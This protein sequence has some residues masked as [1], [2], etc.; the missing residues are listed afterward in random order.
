MD[1]SSGLPDA[2]AWDAFRDSRGFYWIATL[3]GLALYD[4]YTIKT[5]THSK[6]KANSLASNWCTQI[7][8][9]KDKYIIINNYRA[10]SIYRYDYDDFVSISL[11][12]I[13]PS[14]T[15]SAISSLLISADNK[16][17]LSLNSGT[18]LV[19][20]DADMTA[21]I[22]NDKANVKPTT[23]TFDH[24]SSK[25]NSTLERVKLDQAGNMW[26]CYYSGIYLAKNFNQNPKTSVDLILPG[27]YSTVFEDAQK[28]IWLTCYSGD[29]T[30]LTPLPDGTYSTHTYTEEVRKQVSIPITGF[31]N[32]VQDND[33]LYY[34]GLNNGGLITARLIQDKLY[35]IDHIY[36]NT[37]KSNEVT[38]NNNINKISLSDNRV[39]SLSTSTGVL[40]VNLQSIQMNNYSIV[41]NNTGLEFGSSTGKII[42][43]RDKFLCATENEGVY[44]MSLNDAKH[45]ASMSRILLDN[46]LVYDVVADEST[47]TVYIA[48]EKGLLVI[49]ESQILSGHPLT[50][51]QYI[52]QANQLSLHS[53]VIISLY[54]DKN[55]VL[56]LGTGRGLHYMD[57]RSGAIYRV[58]NVRGLEKIGDN[59]IIRDLVMDS[60]HIL[61]IATNSGLIAYDPI[62]KV[63]EQVILPDTTD[64]QIINSAFVDS[65]NNLW[66]GSSAGLYIKKA[67][68]K[69][70]QKILNPYTNFDFSIRGIVEENDHTVWATSQYGLLK[71]V[72][73]NITAHYTSNDGLN[74]NIFNYNSITYTSNGKII[75]GN[76]KG[77]NIFNGSA[78]E[79][80][81]LAGKLIIKD[82]KNNNISIFSNTDISA[83]Y[84]FRVKNRVFLPAGTNSFTIEYALLGNPFLENVLYQYKL[85]DV[86][87]VWHNA[88]SRNTI[89]FTNIKCGHYTLNVRAS[90]GENKWLYTSIPLEI[91]IA[92]FFYQTWWFRLSIGF[93]L[94]FLLSIFIY[95]RFLNLHEKREKELAY[96]K[97]KMNEMFL[98]NMNHEIRTPLN[99]IIGLTKLLIEK[100]PREDQYTYLH[101]MK[102]SADHL[103]IIINDILDIA[104]IDSGKMNIDLHT[105]D[106]DECITHLESSL[107]LKAADKNVTLTLKRDFSVPQYII[108]D[109]TR[110]VQILINLIS[111][112]I[113][114]TDKGSIEVLIQSRP[115]ENYNEKPRLRVSIKDTGIGIPQ[116]KHRLIFESFSQADTKTSRKYGGTGLG[117]NICKS[118]LE[119]QGGTI[120]LESIVG[121]GTTFYFDLPYTPSNKDKVEHLDRKSLSR[122]ASEMTDMNV[123]L[124]EDN[125]FNRLVAVETIKYYFPEIHVDIAVNGL[126]ALKKYRLND[127]DLI[128]MD[129][130]MPEMDGYETTRFIRTQFP[131]HK[132]DIFILAMTANALQPDI[133]KAFKSGMNEFIPKPFEI[134]DLAFKMAAAYRMRISQRTGSSA[135]NRNVDSGNI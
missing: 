10:I 33:S 130:Q 16:L 14:L 24:Q 111:N 77:L 47:H 106:L 102:Q 91:H 43:I 26:L 32:M 72:D 36:N 67:G 129:I 120:W 37:N 118:L 11:E 115:S 109:S 8:E 110:F 133:E 58:E 49:N 66:V 54:L 60:N 123:L 105:F 59:N 76:I 55:N 23:F 70:F 79:K 80:H 5:Y 46:V 57:T 39:L 50:N 128:L 75:T 97:A 107:K 81:P 114:F 35:I 56:W 96:H 83:I 18:V 17:Y 125:E 68:T 127:Y 131:A 7:K 34:I 95:M 89:A 135:I 124:V 122:Y 13:S 9:Y 100:Q 119:L 41:Y 6:L 116:D 126:D 93:L 78:M 12:E 134:N 74:S 1:S 48:T 69:T 108:G 29:I 85:D 62:N 101:V 103:G 2:E 19:Y 51:Y 53:K 28:R 27:N 113:K 52:N 63:A 15:K 104:K 38:I 4:G 3:N 65:K 40:F 71:V 31:T 82:L 90:T 132:K 64:E 22:K 61:W 73:E 98:A 86:D 94:A 20:S 92:S 30:S 99:A 45:T 84:N 121:K 117:L 87:E 25:I 88:G 21:L 44:L 112:A 42:P